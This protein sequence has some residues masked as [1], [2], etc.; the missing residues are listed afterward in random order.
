MCLCAC[1]YVCRNELRPEE[2][3]GFPGAEVT[4]SCESP[5]VG[6][7][8]WTQLLSKSRKQSQLLGH[9]SGP[10]GLRRILTPVEGSYLCD[11]CQD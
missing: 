6:A 8:N 1:V 4:S 3:T 2:G 10:W 9:L 5:D 7:G 11:W